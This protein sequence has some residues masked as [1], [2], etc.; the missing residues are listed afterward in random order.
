ME[1]KEK[2]TV[3]SKEGRKMGSDLYQYKIGT[4]G[5]TPMKRTGDG[6]LFLLSYYQKLLNKQEEVLCLTEKLWPGF[7]HD[8]QQVEILS[9]NK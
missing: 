4:Q 1:F 6:Y 8:I 5:Q 3:I 9:E 7:S 2:E